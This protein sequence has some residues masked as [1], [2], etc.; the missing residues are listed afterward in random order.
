MATVGF[1][2]LGIMGG[3]M[4]GHLAKAGHSLQVYNRGR[5]KAEAW[6]AEHGGMVCHSPAAC[7][8]GADAVITCVGND[9]DLASV[10]L[11][12]D[13]AFRAMKSGSVFVDHTTVSAKIARQLSV[14]A[15]GLGLMAVDAPVTGGEIGAKNGTL[16]L[17]CGGTEKAIAAAAPLMEAYSSRIVHIGPAGAGQTTKMCNQVAFAGT[18]QSLS[19]ALRLA[20]HAELDLD[21]V[22]EAI[23]SG[24]AGSWQMTN[25][26]ATMVK[27]EFDFG[28]PVDWMRKDL[29]LALDEARAN[30]TTLPVAALV[31]QFYAEVQAL[32]GGRQDTSAIVRR[33]PRHKHS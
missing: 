16:T 3:R 23:S 18:I 19:E 14:E 10:T 30:G 33:L 21:R 32:G 6:V 8:E 28:F 27:D 7:A 29:G 1:I 9:D 5:A 22:F 4:A 15:K 17:M 12:R 25:R 31:D 11:G 26:W 13:G 2:G 24:A 20:E